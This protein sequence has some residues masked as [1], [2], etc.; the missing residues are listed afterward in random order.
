MREEANDRITYF[1]LIEMEI[2]EKIPLSYGFFVDIYFCRS[3]IRV[4]DMKRTKSQ[5]R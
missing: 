4:E 5:I 2:D 1:N 3:Y